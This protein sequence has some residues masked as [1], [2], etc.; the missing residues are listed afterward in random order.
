MVWYGNGILPNRLQSELADLDMPP[1]FFDDNEDTS[2]LRFPCAS[3]VA[4]CG[5]QGGWRD[6]VSAGSSLLCCGSCLVA[7]SAKGC[8]EQAI[9]QYLG[10][11]ELFSDGSCTQSAGKVDITDHDLRQCKDFDTR[12][13][14]LNLLG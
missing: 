10:T 6:C 12:P 1:F 11:L 9:N 13:L 3:A 4:G 8:T 14:G 2:T 5:T 7:I